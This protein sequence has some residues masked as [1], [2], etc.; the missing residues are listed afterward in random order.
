MRF[1]PFLAA[2]RFSVASLAQWG[3]FRGRNDM[4]GIRVLIVDDFAEWRQFVRRAIECIAEPQNIREACDGEEA[5]K[6]TRGWTPHL[7]LLDIGIPKMNGI[8]LARQ[9]HKLCPECRVVFFTE[10]RSNDV[11]EECFRA[12]ACAYIVKSS[13]ANDLVAAIKVAIKDKDL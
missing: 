1:P 3:S 11:M 2:R 13:G 7:A 6:K 4:H 12:G 8:E 9:I 5:I 10:N